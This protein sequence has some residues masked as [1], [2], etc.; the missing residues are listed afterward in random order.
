MAKLKIRIELNKGRVGIPL[1]KLV[2]I[3]AETEKFLKMICEDIGIASP[4]WVAK[5]FENNSVDFDCECLLEE[6]KMEHRG[7]TAIRLVVQGK[8]NDSEFGRII[9]PA[10]WRQFAE[11]VRPIDADETVG[12]GVYNGKPKA[13]MFSVPKERLHEESE[14]SPL[15]G[16][17]YGEVQGIVHA[18]YKGSDE[19]KLVI[20][21]LSSKALVDCFFDTKN[22]AMYQTAVQLLEDPNAVI[23][24]EGEIEE[25]R[26]TGIVNNVKVKD[27]RLAPKFNLVKFESGIGSF[28]N[29]TGEATTEDFIERIRTNGNHP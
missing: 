25:N 10:T 11:I 24:V 21:E 14:L 8:R 26:D 5:D 22:K 28:P 6:D 13:E 23:F 1:S 16:K 19:P 12:F 20:R 9:R 18:F 7:Y 27:F 4:T 29:L 3:G 17:Y 2:A 15:V